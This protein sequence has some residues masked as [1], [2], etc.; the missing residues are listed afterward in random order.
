MLDTE[1]TM[2]TKPAVDIFRIAGEVDQTICP[3]D[4]LI[5][6]SSR[7]YSHIH[8]AVDGEPILAEGGGGHDGR[9]IGGYSGTPCNG[10]C[11]DYLCEKTCNKFY[12]N[13]NGPF[14]VPCLI[15][16]EEALVQDSALARYA[17]ETLRDLVSLTEMIKAESNPQK[18][19]AIADNALDIVK[20]VDALQKALIAKFIVAA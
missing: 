20:A 1:F 12:V 6:R 19:T 11:G 9:S 5:A 15:K 14:C 16:A 17:A 18:V 4:C 3:D 10:D 7:P 2:S 13:G 8:C